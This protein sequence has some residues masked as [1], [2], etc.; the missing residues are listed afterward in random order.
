MD[1]QQI[2]LQHIHLLLLIIVANG[3]PIILSLIL[4]Q[5]FNKAIDFN[6]VLADGY[7]I[8]GPSKTWRGLVAALVLTF[9]VAHLL[10]YPPLIGAYI[11]TAAMTGDLISSFVKRRLKIVRI[12][13]F[14]C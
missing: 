1:L 5:H 7:P 11:A 8:W 10:S 14:Y 6:Y 13:K 2:N 12:A 3:G 9:I 4:G